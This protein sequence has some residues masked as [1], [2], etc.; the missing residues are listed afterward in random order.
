MAADRPIVVGTDGS[1]S[2]LQAVSWAA[3]EAALRNAPLT[4]LTTMLR[5]GVY[6][7]PVGLPA[8]F[9]EE[10]ELEAKKRLARA[11]EV[12]ADAVPGHSLEIHTVL[13]TE[14]PAGELVERSK[15]AR[16]VVVGANRQGIIERMFLGSVSSAVATHAHCPVAVIHGLPDTD[17]T[18]LAGPVV[19]GVDGSA[20]TEPAI[21]MAFEEAELRHTELVAV[22][23]WSDVNIPFAFEDGDPVWMQIVKD[24]TAQLSE[25]LVGH[26]EKCP[27]V[28]IRPVVVMDQ[29]AHSLREQAENAQLLV[30]GSRGRGGFASMLLGSTTRTLMNSVNRPLLIVR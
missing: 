12:A 7:A 13:G 6:G 2:A 25:S 17:I 10:E 19:V 24:E 9:F 27:G 23:A 3:K 4:V 30:V 21:A 22:H 1:P 26:A 20:H 5:P 11:A 16:M 18:A 29:P 15:T 28:T 8:N 14:T